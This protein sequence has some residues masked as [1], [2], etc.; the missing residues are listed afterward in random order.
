MAIAIAAKTRIHPVETLQNDDNFFTNITQSQDPVFEAI[1]EDTPHDGTESFISMLEFGIPFPKKGTLSRAVTFRLAQIQE[2]F[3]GPSVGLE[4]EFVPITNPQS[5]SDWEVRIVISDD[6]PDNVTEENML[7]FRVL[8]HPGGSSSSVSRIVSFTGKSFTNGWIKIQDHAANYP[9]WTIF[10]GTTSFR[11]SE[12]RTLDFSKAEI[13]VQVANFSIDKEN[14]DWSI[15]ITQ[16]QVTPPGGGFSSTATNI[17]DFETSDGPDFIA[18][19]TAAMRS[20]VLHLLT[21]NMD[22]RVFF[23]PTLT[24]ASDLVFTYGLLQ[25]IAISNLRRWSDLNMQVMGITIDFQKNTMK[26]RCTNDIYEELGYR[27]LIARV[28]SAEE[29]GEQL[30]LIEN[31]KS[32]LNPAKRTRPYEDSLPVDAGGFSPFAQPFMSNP[33]SDGFSRKDIDT[34]F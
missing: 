5:E 33:V 8:L 9:K 16:I 21:R 26:V 28:E 17:S 22:E 25:S 31:I 11:L 24:P 1:N 20:A 4:R 6:T 34:A 14:F 32:R 23:E 15:A 13:E 27:E 10:D 12:M 29:R 18:D 2:F 30:N 7:S 19:H 3:S